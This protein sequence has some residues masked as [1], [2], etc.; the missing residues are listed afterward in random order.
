M[1]RARLTTTCVLAVHTEGQIKTKFTRV[2]KSWFQ[3]VPV[4]QIH[5][6]ICNVSVIQNEYV[7]SYTPKSAK[8]GTGWKGQKHIPRCT[9]TFTKL[10][11]KNKWNH[12]RHLCAYFCN[13]KTG[14][15]FHC[16]SITYFTRYLEHSVLGKFDWETK[17][18]P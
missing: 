16:G 4:I 17:C 6:D 3:N 5:S 11:D 10:Y 9:L 18:L 12:L 1:A 2:S 7:T 8:G 13:E 14:F 15:W